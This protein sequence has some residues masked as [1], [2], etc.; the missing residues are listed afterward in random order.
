MPIF[1]AA[2]EYNVYV[3][4]DEGNLNET[5]FLLSVESIEGQKN[6]LGFCAQFKTDYSNPYLTLKLHTQA[7]YLPFEVDDIKLL[8]FYSD[9][10][11]IVPFYVFK[12]VFTPT[13]MGEMAKFS[14]KTFYSI[15]SSQNYYKPMSHK[16]WYTSDKSI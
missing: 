13:Y 11:S 2:L 3:Y 6:D 14:Y 16:T 10:I 4:L 7:V 12:I 15:E 5:N 8:K 9:S 1:S